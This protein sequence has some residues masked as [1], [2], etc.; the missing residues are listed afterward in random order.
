MKKR[1]MGRWGDEEKIVGFVYLPPTSP[2]PYLP[3]SPPPHLP[4][5]RP[6]DLPTSPSPDLPTSLIPVIFTLP[7]LS[8]C[9]YNKNK[10]FQDYEQYLYRKYE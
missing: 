7:L 6:P 5:S 8:A 1:E 4:I 10:Y 9:G 3:T 2:P